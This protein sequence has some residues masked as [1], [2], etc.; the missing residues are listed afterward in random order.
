[1][2]IKGLSSFAVVETF[3][4]V[5]LFV[6]GGRQNLLGL[7]VRPSVR[8]FSRLSVT[9]VVN[10]IFRKRLNRCCC[11]LP[12]MVHRAREWNIQLWG[13]VGQRSRSHETDIS[14][15]REHSFSKA[16]E[17]ILL[18]NWHTQVVH[19]ESGWSGQLLDQEVKVQG[20]RTQKLDLG[21][22]R[23]HRSRPLRSSRFSALVMWL[24]EMCGKSKFGSDSVF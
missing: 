9:D 21:T 8:P 1:V 19:R 17:L 20:H 7:S 23:R 3:V 18:R 13:S 11:K 10:A 4:G 24:L 5:T 6:T 15:S 12:Q 2:P 16:D 22:W 14:Q